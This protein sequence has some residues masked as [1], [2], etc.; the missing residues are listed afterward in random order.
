[1][2]FEDCLDL[3]N[4]RTIH[5]RT[6]QRNGR[7]CFTLIEF[8]DNDKECEKLIKKLKKIQSCGGYTRKDEN[9]GKYV[10]ILN[11]DHRAFIYEYLTSVEPYCN[12][13]INIHGG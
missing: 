7:K 13:T 1:M 4:N 10:V 6:Q 8:F 5:I 11:G 3:E 12:S 2:N 9:S